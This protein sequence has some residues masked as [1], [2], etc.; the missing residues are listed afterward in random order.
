MID[1]GSDL[2]SEHVSSPTGDRDNPLL[3]AL[4]TY[5]TSNF[6]ETVS[7]VCPVSGFSVSRITGNICKNGLPYASEWLIIAT[8]L[9]G[10]RVRLLTRDYHKALPESLLMPYYKMQCHDFERIA[11]PRQQVVIHENAWRRG[12]GSFP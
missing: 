4:H 3:C 5:E 6:V 11:G 9:Y 12:L 10:I 8:R 7:T 2:Y 1:L